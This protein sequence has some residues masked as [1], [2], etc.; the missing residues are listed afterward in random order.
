[1]IVMLLGLVLFQGCPTPIIQPPTSPFNRSEIQQI[2]LALKKEEQRVNTFFSTVRLEITTNGTDTE[3]NALIV[4]TRSPFRVKIEITHP[5]GRPVLHVLMTHNRIRALSFTEKRYYEGR[6][7]DMASW[8]F[9]P[10]QLDRHLIWAFFRGYPVL[11]V[12]QAAVS[13]KGNQISLLGEGNEAVQVIDLHAENRY[14]RLATYPFEKLAMSF[15]GFQGPKNIPYARKVVLD[16]SR[17]RS[18]LTLKIKKMV[19]NPVVPE[20]VFQLEIP[21][22]FKRQRLHPSS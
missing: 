16:D 7:Q 22:D 6:V 10:G 3:S 5:W 1:M 4:G 15:S 12:H 19:M 21:P 8:G 2:I 11:R 14:P 18:M 13:V 17:S 9:F 20:S